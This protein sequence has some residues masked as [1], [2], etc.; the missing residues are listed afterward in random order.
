MES[1]R[2]GDN[3]RFEEYRKL[4]ELL[5]LND[6]SP[7]TVR[8]SSGIGHQHADDSHRNHARE[9]DN[10]SNNRG[11]LKF[12]DDFHDHTNL[13]IEKRK[14]IYNECLIELHALVLED[15]DEDD[16]GEDE[17]GSENI[18]GSL[19]KQINTGDH[20]VHSDHPE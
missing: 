8:I 16:E 12:P 14:R 19:N 7:G 17:L 6:R 18:M 15:D 2:R 1:I 4:L 10:K 13:S 20:N 11:S 3:Y 5:C 9:D